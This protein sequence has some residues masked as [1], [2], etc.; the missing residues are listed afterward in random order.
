MSGSTVISVHREVIELEL[1]E[2]F[3]ISGG[4]QEV[5][6]I[7]LVRL[8]LADG[9]LGLGEAAPLP[10]YNGERVEDALGA[11]DAAGP[12]WLGRDASAWRQ[13]A[14]ELQA[15]TERSA[16]ARCALETALFDALSRRAQTSL[17]HWLGGCLPAELE[18]D[19]TI[20][21]V[22]ADA[23]R[24]AAERWWQRGFRSL[25]LKIGA[26]GDLE[27]ILA[28][29]E[30]A[31]AAQLLLDA[32]GGLDAPRA[33]ALLSAL[34]RRGVRIDL[35]E[36]PVPA[37]DWAGLEQV[38]RRVRV[39]LDESVVSPRDAL[40]AARRLGPPHVIN[41]KLMKSGL[42]GALDI[43]ASARASGMSLMI[44]GMLESSLAMSASACFAAGHGGFEFVDL[45]TPLFML[46]SPFVG[47]FTS[48]GNRLDVSTIRAGHGV[49]LGG[50]ARGASPPPG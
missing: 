13:R 7:A 2:P 23:A 6:R 1:S 48:R 10:A 26:D 38:A 16:S 8:E 18:T 3:G 42:L 45:D 9:T 46:D 5:A 4:S 44:G 33:L 12:L 11:I 31:P 15:A 40:E 43:V 21:I 27:R 28:A 24:A 19:V 14:L 50:V 17:Y 32:N 47:G 35:F 41:V 30:G 22:D 37:R 25:K 39:A 49:S 20:P 36:Q 29:H 34:E